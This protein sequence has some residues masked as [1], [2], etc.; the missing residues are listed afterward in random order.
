MIVGKTI[1]QLESNFQSLLEIDMDPAAEK[2]IV[3]D[4]R[5]FAVTYVGTRPALGVA[6]VILPSMYATAHYLIVGIVDNDQV[7]IAEF[8]DGIKLQ[9]VDV[10]IAD[11][12]Q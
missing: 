3:I 7:Y 6:K 10:N 4:R 2:F 11:L 12:S 9:V 5:S 8:Q 1:T